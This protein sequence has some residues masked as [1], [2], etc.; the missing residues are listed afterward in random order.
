M[1]IGKKFFALVL[2]VILLLSL[3]ACGSTRPTTVATVSSPYHR[4][5][6]GSPAQ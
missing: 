1:K 4:C 3:T 5:H 6:R 2:S